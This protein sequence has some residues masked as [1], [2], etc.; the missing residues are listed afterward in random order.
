M[1]FEI[2]V[3]IIL[4]F[5]MLFNFMTGIF[6]SEIGNALQLIASMNHDEKASPPIITKTTP[7]T[8]GACSWCFDNGTTECEECK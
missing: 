4:L 8:I 3:I 7:P 1:W 6:I 5:I 2:A